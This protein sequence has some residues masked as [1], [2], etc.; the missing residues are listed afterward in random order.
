[1]AIGGM[2]RGMMPQ[3]GAAPPPAQPQ[4]F[5][6]PQSFESGPGGDP[7]LIPTQAGGPAPVTQP[8]PDLV[9]T[10]AGRMPIE[11]AQKFGFALGLAGKGDAGKMFIDAANANK[12]DKKARNDVEE[13]ALNATESI[14]RLD[15]IISTYKPE[16]LTW[17][18]QAKQ[19][20]YWLTGKIGG[21]LTP[22]QAQART[23]YATFTSNVQKNLNLYIKEITGAAM[24][25]QEAKRIEASIANL[26]DDPAAFE[27]KLGEISRDARMA[28]ARQKYLMKNGFKGDANAAS[29]MMP[30]G[31]VPFVYDQRAMEIE[32]GIT[33]ANPSM[34]PD[35]IRS[36]T[37]QQLK[38]EFGI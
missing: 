35:Q 34:N 11:Q 26:G 36:M 37:K 18:E 30:L 21:K 19:G 29:R 15:Q 1:M 24:A 17:G 8:G 3:Q 4:N 16:F 5:L 38:Q 33:A 10:P 2:I 12:L 27:A 25:I 28:V 31:Q 9:D 20:A 13:R 7:M 6:R 14:S 23:G 32:R 22:E